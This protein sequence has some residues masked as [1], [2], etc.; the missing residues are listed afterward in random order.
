MSNFMKLSDFTNALTKK[1]ETHKD[2][3]FYTVYNNRSNDTFVESITNAVYVEEKDT[4]RLISKNIDYMDADTMFTKPG[5]FSNAELF[6][7]L[8]WK[9]DVQEILDELTDGSYSIN[10]FTEV[11]TF[12]ESCEKPLNEAQ[13]PI[14]DIIDS[15]VEDRH[16]T[17]N[18]SKGEEALYD[19]YLE[20][21]KE[22]ENNPN[23]DMLAGDIL[24]LLDNKETGWNN[25]VVEWAEDFNIDEEAA[26]KIMVSALRNHIELD[27]SMDEVI[28]ITLDAVFDDMNSEKETVKFFEEKYP[29]IKV[30]ITDDIFDNLKL[31][32]SKQDLRRYILNDYQADEEFI[33]EYYPELNESI[34]NGFSK[35]EMEVA[36]ILD[37][38]G[39]KVIPSA[40][41]AFADYI[42]MSRDNGED[43]SVKEW[44][45]DTEE[46]YP[47]ELEL[48]ESCEK[49]LNEA[50]FEETEI[51]L[52]YSSKEERD[53]V[54]DAA[55]KAGLDDKY[56]M[57]KFEEI[58]SGDDDSAKMLLVK[59]LSNRNSY[60]VLDEV[61]EALEEAS[62]TTPDDTF[63]EGTGFTLDES[64]CKGDC[65]NEALAIN[66]R[67]NES[68]IR[69]IIEADTLPENV[70]LDA[71]LRFLPDNTLGE[72]LDGE[73]SELIDYASEE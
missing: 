43:Y 14:E 12:D 11:A 53:L 20:A 48:K 44:L 40:V 38:N 56:E 39:Y 66:A 15:V 23:A 62:G 21:I 47:E 41:E 18:E 33:T 29:N 31:T 50:H 67:P 57:N 17:L 37:N 3:D 5:D 73:L 27:E 28:S 60:T 26:R 45:K 72:F 59:V 69:D 19:A 9:H 49:S 71:L 61:C 35:L 68:D 51:S 4:G 58:Y 46:N 6:Y 24:K 10:D 54:Y 16:A 30:E 64:L 34:E 63:V 1:Y 52:L 65:C 36:N 42:Q 2:F 7:S 32:G 13:A 55:M 25:Y 22:E 70:V 8:T